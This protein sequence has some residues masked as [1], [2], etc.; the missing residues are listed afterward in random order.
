M[1]DSPGSGYVPVVNSCENS[2]EHLD[3]ITTGHLS[4]KMSTSLSTATAAGCRFTVHNLQLQQ[5]SKITLINNSDD[6]NRNDDHNS[7]K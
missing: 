2:S 5:H 4:S 3:T 1:T 7:A 6:D